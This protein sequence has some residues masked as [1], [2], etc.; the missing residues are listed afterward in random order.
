MFKQQW[1]QKDAKLSATN[2]CALH[3]HVLKYT[4]P[5]PQAAGVKATDLL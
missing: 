1:R 4:A 5:L 2:L 3:V